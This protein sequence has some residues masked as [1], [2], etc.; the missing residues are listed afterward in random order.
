MKGSI[1]RGLKAATDILLPRQC[2]T[3]GRKLLL[4]EK[5]LC[6][7][8]LADLPQTYFWTLSHNPMADKFNGVIQKTLEEG[9]SSDNDC[10]TE[11]SDAA[12]ESCH[13]HYAFA[14]ALFFYHSEAEYRLI[15]YQ[16]KYHGNISAGQYFGKM[17]G[18]RLAS[19][20]VFQDVDM[21]IPVPLHWTRKWKRGYNQAEVIASAVAESL[22][23]PMRT[24][25]LKRCKRTSTQTKVEVEEKRKNVSGAF[26]AAIPSAADISPDEVRHLLIVDDVFTTGSTLFACFVALRSVFPPSVRISVA[27][28]GFVGRA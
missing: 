3:C 15:P 1:L 21:V 16:I 22:G 18:K 5:H 17:L 28:L 6:I 24:D 23:A 11:A 10:S 20:E 13:E 27:T 4:N 8:C 26:A 12:S 25:I 14:S 19:S 7:G 9:S 2:I